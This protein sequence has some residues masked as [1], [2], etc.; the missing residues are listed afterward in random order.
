[1]RDSSACGNPVRDV[2]CDL[3]RDLISGLAHP[4]EAASKVEKAYGLA[5]GG[6]LLDC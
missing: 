4:F 3:A 1:M 6:D 2:P 5:K